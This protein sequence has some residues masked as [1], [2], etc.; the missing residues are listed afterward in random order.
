VGILMS[1]CT[2]VRKL[3]LCPSLIWALESLGSCVRYIPACCM[4]CLGVCWFCI[5]YC[6]Y[7][8]VFIWWS[9]L[10]FIWSC[11]GYFWSCLVFIWSCIRYICLA[12]WSCIR[13]TSW[14]L[15]SLFAMCGMCCLAICNREV[16]TNPMVISSPSQTW[17]RIDS[18]F[19]LWDIPIQNPESIWYGVS[20]RITSWRDQSQASRHTVSSFS[21][22]SVRGDDPFSVRFE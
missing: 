13:Y 17:D 10:G 6:W 7:C 21:L 15:W 16:N 18:P 8:M 11:L 3:S 22:D 1:E 2:C 4:G 12:I 9:C 14:A 19:Q 20:H 5:R